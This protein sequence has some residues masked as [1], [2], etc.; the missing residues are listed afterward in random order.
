MAA[1]V[2]FSKSEDIIMAKKQWSDMTST[3]K[4][5]TVL[6]VGAQIVMLTAA[7]LNIRRQPEDQINGSKRL[8][9]ALSFVNFIGPIAYFIWGRKR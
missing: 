7:L 6:L 3:Q 9:A 5:G 4:T 8:W 2:V 1:S